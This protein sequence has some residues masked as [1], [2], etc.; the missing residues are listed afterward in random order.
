MQPELTHVALTYR[1]RGTTRRAKV[2]TEPCEICLSRE[3]VGE[4]VT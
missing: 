1:V 2:Q 4:P 3:N